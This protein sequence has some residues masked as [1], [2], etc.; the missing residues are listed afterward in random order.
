[1]IANK[2]FLEAIKQEPLYKGVN[3]YKGMIR[4]EAVAETFQ[5][6]YEALVIT[7]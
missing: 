1:M 3:T 2:G 6:P 5:L 4:Y 7:K